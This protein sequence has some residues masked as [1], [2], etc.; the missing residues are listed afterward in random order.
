MQQSLGATAVGFTEASEAHASVVTDSR[1]LST[2]TSK[3]KRVG[4]RRRSQKADS[5]QPLSE[6]G[7]G[8]SASG[9]VAYASLE[10]RK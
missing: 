2:Y 8:E 5:A 10:P 7:P 9:K 4:W 1:V 3:E 6:E